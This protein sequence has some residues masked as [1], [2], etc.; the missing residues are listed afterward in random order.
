MRGIGME[1]EDVYVRWY[2]LSK[3]KPVGHVHHHSFERAAVEIA[4]AER[5]D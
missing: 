1:Q 3:E 4:A 2:M 5:F